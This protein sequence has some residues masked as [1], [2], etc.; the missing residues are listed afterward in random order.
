MEV[1]GNIATRQEEFRIRRR[2][3]SELT[4]VFAHVVVVKRKKLELVIVRCKEF[5]DSAVALSAH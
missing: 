4:V 1:G 3:K 2:E 5:S